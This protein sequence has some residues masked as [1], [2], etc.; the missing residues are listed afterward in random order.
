MKIGNYS[1]DLY[2]KPFEVWIS[3]WFA[4]QM[5]GLCAMFY[6]LGWPDQYVKNKMETT[7]HVFKWLEWHL[8]TR[9]FG[10]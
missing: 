2:T 6:V 4:I 9:T 5:V 1:E 3:K 8:N 10:I 7:S